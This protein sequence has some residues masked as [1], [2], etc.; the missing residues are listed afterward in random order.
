MTPAMA[1]AASRTA[2]IGMTRDSEMLGKRSDRNRRIR[3]RQRPGARTPEGLCRSANL[4]GDLF[5][6]LSRPFARLAALACAAWTCGALCAHAQEAPPAIGPFVVDLHG[7]ALSFP[8]DAALAASRGLQQNDMPGFGLGGDVGVHVYPLRWRAVTFGLGGR[9]AFARSRHTP[10]PGVPARPAVTEQF[11]SIAPQIS[12]N[13]GKGDGWSYLSGG[14]GRSTWSIVPDGRS[15]LP[16]DEERLKT[17]DY[18]GG[19]RW[20]IRPHLAFSLDV[21]FYAINPGTPASGYPG[22]PRTTFL[23]AGAGISVN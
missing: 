9:L 15:E 10:L 13:F 5:P 11:L 7:A 3:E 22:S 12:L 16:S 2:S 21:R 20:F 1:T 19:A 4:S 6:R 23:I 8:G 14:L 18:G 17:L